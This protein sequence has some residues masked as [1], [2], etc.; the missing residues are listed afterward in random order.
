MIDLDKA[1]ANVVKTGKVVLGAEEAAESARSGKAQVIIVASS[2]RARIHEDLKYYG[3]LSEIPIVLYNGSSVDL[4]MTCGKRF[5]VSAL[6]VKEQ[7]DSNILDIAQEFR[8]EQVTSEKV[9]V[10]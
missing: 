10:P 7:G 9:E 2:G 6:T 5:A 1:I 4:G 3:H 8:K